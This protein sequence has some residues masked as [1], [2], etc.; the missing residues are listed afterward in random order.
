[1]VGRLATKNIDVCT[2]SLFFDAEETDHWKITE[3]EV[4]D[5][6]VFGCKHCRTAIVCPRH[7]SQF[8]R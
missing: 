1:M 4:E 2:I 6:I 3:M 5:Y 7:V 8:R